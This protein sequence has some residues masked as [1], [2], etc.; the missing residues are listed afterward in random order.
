MKTFYRRLR[1][2]RTDH[3]MTQQQVA[4]YLGI[5]RPQYTR[6]ENGVRDLPTYTLIRLA[7]LYK[8][9]VDYILG[10]TNNPKPYRDIED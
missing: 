2:L 7:V 1:D 3:D 5:P 8:T 10:I 6:Y 9:S 4:D